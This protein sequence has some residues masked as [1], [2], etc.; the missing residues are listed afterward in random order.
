MAHY[1]ERANL[2]IKELSY[3][4]EEKPEKLL[5][6]ERGSR[7]PSLRVAM[8]YHILF[9]APLQFMYSDLYADLYA[10]VVERSSRLIAKQKHRQPS[11]SSHNYSSLQAIVK[12]ITDNTH[13]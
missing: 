13:E 10:Q 11:K 4:L 5:A 1:R 3:L 7:L 12:R 2:Q 9:D 6:M 8:L